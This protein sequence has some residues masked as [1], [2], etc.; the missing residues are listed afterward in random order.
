VNDARDDS[1]VIAK[2]YLKI[3]RRENEEM[4]IVSSRK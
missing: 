1:R 4:A 2:D 3:E